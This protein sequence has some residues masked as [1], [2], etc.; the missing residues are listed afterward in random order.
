[1]TIRNEALA[2]GI[3]TDQHKDRNAEAICC[4][5]ACDDC[6]LDLPAEST[7]IETS[8]APEPIEGWDAGDGLHLLALL[9]AFECAEEMVESIKSLNRRTQN[10]DLPVPNSPVKEATNGG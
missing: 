7:R 3:N 10:P 2:A 8:S 5:S 1:M 4:R 6:L 9:E